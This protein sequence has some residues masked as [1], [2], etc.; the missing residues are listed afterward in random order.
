MENKLKIRIKKRIVEINKQIKTATKELKFAEEVIDSDEDLFQEHLKN[1]YGIHQ[2][3]S[4]ELRNLASK[5]IE[6]SHIIETLFNEEIQNSEIEIVQFKNNIIKI[7]MPIIT[8]FSIYKRLKLYPKDRLT[9]RDIEAIDRS[10]L[11]IKTLARAI[12]KFLEKNNIDRSIYQN[13]TLMYVNIFDNDYRTD[14]IPDTDNYSYKAITDA[15]ACN[16]ILGGD[17]AFNMDFINISVNGEKIKTEI[18]LI[19][20]Q[21]KTFYN[22]IVS[23]N[24][25]IKQVV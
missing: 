23:H 22:R 1:A 20:A 16:F 8:P 3:S 19:P 24:P 18:Y 11:I 5:T 12:N 25:V 10:D 2:K 4:I 13:T 21:F 7:S 15:I 6:N 14:R 9:V 17:S